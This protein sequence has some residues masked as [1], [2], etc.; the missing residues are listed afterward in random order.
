M[1]EITTGS[2]TGGVIAANAPLAF[3]IELMELSG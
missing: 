2:G 1:G 3:E